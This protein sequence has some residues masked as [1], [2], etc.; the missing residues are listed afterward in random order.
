M[1]EAP[2]PGRYQQ[3][4]AQT[5]G[6]VLTEMERAG[7]R[8][9]FAARPGGRIHCFSCGHDFAPEGATVETV[10]RLEGASDPADMLAVLPVTCPSCAGRGTLVLGYGPEST[11]E[12]SEVLAA[13]PAADRPPQPGSDGTA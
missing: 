13:L 12:D 7:F 2:E 4:E 8:E 6:A 3:S 9:Q 1:A 11:L 5:L 10:R